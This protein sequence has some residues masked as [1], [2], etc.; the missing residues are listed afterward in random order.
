MSLP[1]HPMV[2]VFFK[3]LFIYRPPAQCS[4]LLE[5]CSE[6]RIDECRVYVQ[7]CLQQSD[8]S[9]SLQADHGKQHDLARVR[10]DP[11][12]PPATKL[13][14]QV[15]DAHPFCSGAVTCLHCSSTWP[16]AD[17]RVR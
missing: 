6:A 5:H 10:P 15:I 8:L 1:S 13:A 14:P 9:C 3:L 2:V 7:L 4:S 16:S 11:S 17:L 12:R